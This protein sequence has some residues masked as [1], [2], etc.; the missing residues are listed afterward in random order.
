MDSR[1]YLLLVV[2][3]YLKEGD[4]VFFIQN[5]LPQIKQLD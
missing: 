4:L 3:R 5:F 2:Q 1:S